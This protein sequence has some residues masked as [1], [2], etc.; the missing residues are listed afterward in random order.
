MGLTLGLVM[1]RAG[2]KVI[3]TDKDK[4]RLRQL[5][6]GILPFYEPHLKD[7]FE[8]G[9]KNCR[10]THRISEICSSS[11]LFFTFNMRVRPQGDFDISDVLEWTK[12]I[13]DNTETEKIIV[14]K[15]TFS[16]GTHQAVSRWIGKT[17]HLQS[18]T[19]PEFLKTGEA[20]S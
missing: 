13:R 12:I 5:S 17:S 16:P 3:F 18:V 20:I 11:I 10:W 15:S 7:I 8:A 6:Q 14:L 1:A 2:H 9:R 4:N 19:C